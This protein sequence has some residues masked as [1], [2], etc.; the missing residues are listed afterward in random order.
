MKPSSFIML[1][2][3]NHLPLYFYLYFRLEGG[4]LFVCSLAGLLVDSF[5]GWFVCWFVRSV[6]WYVR[7]LV[8]RS[9]GRSDDPSVLRSVGPLVRLS[10]GPSVGRSGGTSVRI[11]INC[12]VRMVD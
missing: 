10:D 7:Q 2:V 3:I 8:A 12:S 5:V 1:F 4:Q 11:G 9:V 6:G